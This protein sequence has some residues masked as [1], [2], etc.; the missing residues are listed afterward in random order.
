MYSLNELKAGQSIEV[1]GDPF[2]IMSAKFGR[3]S[4]GQANNVTK[5]KN[6]KTGAVIS[7]T[8][9]GDN[10]IQPADVGY[11]HIQFLFSGG[12]T[13]TFMDL[14]D[15]NQFELSAD[16]VGDAKNYLVDGGE[17]DALMYQENPIGIKLP[18]TVILTVKET[19]PGVKGD[20]AQGGTKPATF[21]N[22]LV[23]QVPLFINEGDKI[24]INT[25]RGEYTERV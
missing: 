10:K 20:T 1:D 4:Q 5:L 12:D 15:Y 6:L 17:L 16:K 9:S 21:E 8:F 22:G 13:Y 11:R 2:M 19:P 23:L 24:K 14:N 25:E 3:K 18:S 7:K